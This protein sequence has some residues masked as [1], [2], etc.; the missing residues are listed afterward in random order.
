[1]HNEVG[2][3]YLRNKRAFFFPRSVSFMLEEKCFEIFI[4]LR[5]KNCYSL[6]KWKKSSEKFLGLYSE[7][8]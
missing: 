7:K 1:M 5:K 6:D 4:F 2:T 8:Y 3:F